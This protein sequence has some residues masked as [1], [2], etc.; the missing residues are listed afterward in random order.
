[1]IIK[2][3]YYH[4][5]LKAHFKTYAENSQQRTDLLISI[6]EAVL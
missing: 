2:I 1:M 5:H 3:L 4:K 6:G